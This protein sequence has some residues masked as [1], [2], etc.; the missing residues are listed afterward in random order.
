MASLLR[1][2][3]PLV[4]PEE[5]AIMIRGINVVLDRDLGLHLS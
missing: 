4:F 3:R 2:C 5:G 1:Y